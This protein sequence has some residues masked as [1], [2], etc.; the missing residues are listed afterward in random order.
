MPWNIGTKRF[1]IVFFSSSQRCFFCFSC[2]CVSSCIC[3]LGRPTAMAVVA[4]NFAWKLCHQRRIF[5]NFTSTPVLDLYKPR[6]RGDALIMAALYLLWSPRIFT[7]LHLR[8]TEKVFLDG[9]WQNIWLH[10]MA[11][12]A[13]IVDC[14]EPRTC[15]NNK[16]RSRTW[17]EIA[18]VL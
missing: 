5:F 10:I 15:T 8:P 1:H 17:M 3:F 6:P 14:V 13:H 11:I 4:T 16:Q 7:C 12:W 2:V 18:C 9:T